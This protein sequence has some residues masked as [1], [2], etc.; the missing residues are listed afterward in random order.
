MQHPIHTVRVGSDQA[1][2]ASMPNVAVQAIESS[3]DFVVRH[4]SKIKATI[5]STALADRVVEVKLSEID[6]TGK[7][8][9]KIQAQK[10]VLQSNAGGQVLELNYK[11]LTV[12]V[13]RLAIWIDPIPGERSVLDNRQEFQGLAIDPRIKVL[14]I[15]GRARPEF[16]ELNRALEHDANVELATLLRIQ[17]E[18][19]AA[20]GTIDGQAFRDLPASPS[21]WAKVDVILLGDLD[22]SFLSH[23]QQANIEQRVASG[24]GLLMMG[25]QNSFGPGGYENSPMEKALPVFVGEKTGMQD[26]ME[27]VPR[28]TDEGAAHPILEGLGGWFGVEGKVAEKTLPPLRG[29]VVVPRAKSGAQ[30]LLVHPNETGPDGKPEIIL[31][32][33]MYGQG[34]SAAFTADTTYLWYL[35]LRGMG[36]ESPYN[37]FWGQLI[38][39]LAGQDVRNRQRGAGVQALLSK[40]IFQ[41]GESVRLR[42]LVR[43]EHGDATGYARVT[44]AINH[45]GG[46]PTT[47]SLVPTEIRAG[48][49]EVMLPNV[50]RGDYTVELI[51]TKDEKELG[52]Q[53]VKFTVLPPAD[54][55]FK[56]AANPQLMGAIA[57]ET[58]GLHCDLGEL[59]TLVHELI[60]SGA[61]AGPSEE[62][63]L[64]LSNYIRVG[65]T[66]LGAHPQWPGKY[67]L[68]MQ[69]ILVVALLAG[70]WLLRRRWE[71]V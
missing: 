68:P 37:R 32:T 51:A 8:I 35:P 4:E 31:A 50:P 57:D 64:A 10:L 14:Y 40:T 7:S 59:P 34:R 27:F 42:A 19:F 56:L 3:D 48:M 49:Y 69:G 9:G 67:D 17:Q 47:Y 5:T 70:E 53:S 28:M 36:Q 15:E 62:K 2:P 58:H 26:K 1:E 11:P 25:G 65:A 66:I 41:L 16:R 29:N 54:E 39:W 43:D 61:A 33:Q 18:R 22:S 46:K 21:E 23:Q 63:S 20:A 71:L 45:G 30:V 24:G 6:S 55:M 44:A 13:H 60:R 52:R 38:R 12:G